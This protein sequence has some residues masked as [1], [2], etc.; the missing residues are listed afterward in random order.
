MTDVVVNELVVLIAMLVREPQPENMLDASLTFGKLS[1][2]TYRRL[3][4]DWNIPLEFVTDE[5][6]KFGTVRRLLH[7]ENILVANVALPTLNNGTVFME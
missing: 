7:P 1:S 3:V 6:L 5:K 2:G 4:H